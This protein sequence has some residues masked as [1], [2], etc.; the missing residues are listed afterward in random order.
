MGKALK[1]VLQKEIKRRPE[2]KQKLDE[3]LEKDYYYYN[4]AK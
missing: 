4:K 3:Y 2:L 1:P